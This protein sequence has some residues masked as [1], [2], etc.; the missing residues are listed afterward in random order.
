MSQVSVVTFVTPKNYQLNGLWFGAEKAET[1]FIFLHGLSSSVFSKHDVSS[2]LLDSSTMALYFDNRGH[3]KVSAISHLLPETEKGYEWEPAGE[4]HE[5]FTDCV[6]DIQGAVDFLTSKG[7]K[8][9]YLI[10]HSTGCQKSMYY[11]SQTGSP[12]NIKGVVLI[13]PISDYSYA[14]HAEDPGAIKRALDYARKLVKDGKPHELLPQTIS[15]DLLDAQRYISL[16]TPDS[17]EEIFS[18]AQP[19]KEPTTFQKVKTPTLAIFAE[20]DEYA[21]RPAEQLVQWFKQCSKADS[22][23]TQILPEAIHNLTGQQ[24]ET[25]KLI[26]DWISKLT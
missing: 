23:N 22:I 19:N 24:T 2:P 14:V 13:C 7:V 1:G 15:E 4:A 12:K 8:N 11:L 10:G 9:I 20:N 16:Y 3:D 18:Y 21:D 6:D 25:G 26:K 17:E 5:V